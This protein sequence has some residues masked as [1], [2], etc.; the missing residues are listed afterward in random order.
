MADRLKDRCAIITG[1]ATGMGVTMARLFAE[2][3]ARVVILDINKNAGAEALALLR[4]ISDD[5]QYFPVD[6]TD[7]DDVHET[8]S[9]A[10]E[11]LG[12]TVDILLQE[13]QL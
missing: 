10:A 8:I 12:D 1:G 9:A 3:G 6:V 5:T 4:K 13:P 7:H 11:F 2:E